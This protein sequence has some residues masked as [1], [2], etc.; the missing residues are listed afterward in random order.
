MC[1]SFVASARSAAMV[2][3]FVRYSLPSCS[4]YAV[5]QPTELWLYRNK[6]DQTERQSEHVDVRP[7]H[8]LGS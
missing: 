5:Q 2:G 8:L 6:V 4:D 1:L 7:I 3:L